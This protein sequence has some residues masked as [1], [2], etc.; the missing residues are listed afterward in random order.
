MS[1]LLNELANLF[2]QTRNLTVSLNKLLCRKLVNVV[3]MMI[4]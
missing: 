1:N 4:N 3:I 2:N